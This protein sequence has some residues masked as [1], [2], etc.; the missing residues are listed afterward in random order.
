MHFKHQ[1]KQVFT[2][3]HTL[4]HSIAWET[5]VVKQLTECQLLKEFS[6]IIHEQEEK[7]IGTG[8]VRNA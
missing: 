4:Q 5:P 2:G 1:M 8:L 3:V 6:Q 7:G